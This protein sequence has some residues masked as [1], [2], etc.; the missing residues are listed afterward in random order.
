MRDR[1]AGMIAGI[2][3]AVVSGVV[4]ASLPSPARIAWVGGTDVVACQ[5]AD[6][7][8]SCETEGVL[9]QGL[10][11]IAGENRI[12]Y[13]QPQ[14]ADPLFAI[15]SWGRLVVA[16][17][18]VR[19]TAWKPDRSS[20]RSHVKKLTPAKDDQT[21]IVPIAAGQFWI[22][23]A[24][25]T[26]DND[27]F[28]VLESDTFAR[29]RISVSRLRSGD[30]AT[31]EYVTPVV[32]TTLFGRVQSTAGNDIA[33]TDV[34]L[35]EPLVEDARRSA[36]ELTNTE[37]VRV[38][39]T[40]TAEDGSF[41]FDRLGLGPYVLTVTDESRGRTA[42]PVLAPSAP[43]TV[44]LRPPPRLTGRVLRRQLPVVN[45]RVHLVPEPGTLITAAD[46]R[47]L[48]TRDVSTDMNGRFAFPL[49]P[50]SKGELQISAAD[51]AIA[52]VPVPSVNGDG[53]LDIGDIALPDPRQI[54][55]RLFDGDGCV[56]SATGPTGRLGV[57]TVTEKSA[58]DIVHWLEIP[59][60]GQWMLSASC[61]TRPAAVEPELLTVSDGAGPLTV[62]AHV[63]SR[64]D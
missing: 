15:A 21:T 16:P 55:V 4:P 1:G 44:L 32:A 36:D 12:A 35:F 56:V 14:S 19:V 2:L 22:V 28:V 63:T 53:D 48:A 17:D 13:A 54:A 47:D 38:A 40:R 52:R 37:L 11:V 31:P 29:T 10:V 59:E 23:G 64:R 24:D 9:S 39:I 58:V 41:Q 49:P 30:V 26:S 57:A 5:V 51:S 34:E 43:I 20:W 61:G 7:R 18:A 46:P 3:F 6:R 42:V 25:A 8:W 27:A 45:A 50:V 60:P 33:D 62:D